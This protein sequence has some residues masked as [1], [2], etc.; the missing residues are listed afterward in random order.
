[1]GRWQNQCWEVKTS[2]TQL[3]SGV[4]PQDTTETRILWRSASSMYMHDWKSIHYNRKYQNK[5]SRKGIQMLVLEHS[6]YLV[7]SFGFLYVCFCGR[8]E[9]GS[10]TQILQG[11][12]NPLVRSNLVLCS[13]TAGAT[14]TQACAKLTS[15][16]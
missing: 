9:G 6:C 15:Q 13:Q 14:E 10:V 5:G 3:D 2:L 1:M 12:L 11:I 8:K 7:N 16:F 4:L